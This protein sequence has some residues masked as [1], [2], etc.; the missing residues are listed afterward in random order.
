MQFL[1]RRR[2][3]ILLVTAIA[4][5][6]LAGAALA[7]YVWLVV[8]PNLP[9]LDSLTDYRPK[10]PLRVYTADKV[11][12]GEF[13]AEHRDFV[14][15]NEIPP[16]MK[17]AVV[18]I[19]DSRFYE[20]G[21][22]DFRSGLRAV[23][24]NL[25]R[26][27]SQGGS[28]ITMQVARNFLLTREKDYGRKLTEIIL[29]WEIENRLP[30]DKILELYMNQIFLGERSYGFAAAARV[31]FGKSLKELT[32]AE[33][34][35]L[36]GLPQLPAAAN[37]LVNPK[38][39]KDRR[40]TVLQRM[41]EL[42]YL[43]T[44][45]YEQAKQEDIHLRGRRQQF[46]AHAEYA[47]EMVRQAVYAQYKDEAY[48]RGIN[49]ITTL[50]SREQEAAYQALRRDV[51]EYELRHGYR[52]PEAQ[53]ELPRDEEERQDAI[54]EALLDAPDAG[55]LQ[56]AVVLSATPQAV[57]AQLLSG[58][59]VELRGDAL[60]LAA[61]GLRPNANAKL[62][63]QPG[64]VIRLSQEA[65]PD[66]GQSAKLRW[67]ITQLPQVAAAFVALD[68]RDGAYR[69]LVGGFD[70]GLGK[71][72]HVT[73]AWR[74]PGSSVKPFVYSAALE[75]GLSPATLI[76][77]A[78]FVMT[79]AETGSKAWEPKNDD[80][81]DGPVTMRSALAKSKNV[82]SVRI[83][84]AIGASYARDWLGR[85]G[86]DVDKQPS[87]LTMTLGTGAATPLQMAAAYAVFANGGFRIEPYLT[88]KIT[89]AQGK[90]LSEVQPKRAG[91]ESERVLDVRNAFVMDTMLRDVVRYGTGAAASQKLGRR[92]LAGKTGTTTD[93]VDG[94]FAGYAGDVVAV[95]WMGYDDPKSLGGREFGATLALPIWIDYMRVALAGKPETQ[96]AVPAGLSQVNGDW[97]YD[98]FASQGAV[99][100]LDFDGAEP[101][102]APAVLPANAV[103]GGEQEKKNVLDAFR[104]GK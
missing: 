11:L 33:T 34:A 65:K 50:D 99:Q 19:E 100:T 90:V 6:A 76:N 14:P 62:H 104:D 15:I 8:M 73:Q 30:K 12:I 54:E 9:P 101:S 41:R 31:Y 66:G 44:A 67:T 4:T 78:P 18:A 77:D 55:D 29:A 32:I 26:S 79:S 7:A 69:A 59:V 93:A 28:T 92:D 2:V 68:A 1:T 25:H 103:P 39:A 49:V 81:F 84:R 95:A 21:G 5:A 35:L 46:G 53:I 43:T 86:F 13:G 10:L 47:A 42:G 102:S 94:W 22:I 16:L 80:G 27:R 38:R 63:L 37:P 51:L 75:K 23:V 45:Q 57:R 91:E 52:G 3:V 82:P 61:S 20:H 89:D 40:N 74:Q 87:N 24:A 64:S 17:N 98:E 88:R 36:A 58:D 97:M 72:N 56:P 48:T 70:F 83:L 85:F 60:R 71:F 96:R